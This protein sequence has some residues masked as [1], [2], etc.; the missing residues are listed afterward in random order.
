MEGILIV[1]VKNFFDVGAM[2]SN[3]YIFFNDDYG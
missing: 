3:L 2:L 1:L